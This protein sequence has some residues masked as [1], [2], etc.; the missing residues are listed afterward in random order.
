MVQLPKE[1]IAPEIPQVDITPSEVDLAVI[2]VLPPGSRVT[3]VSAHGAS[4]WAKIY[5]LDVVFV[6]NKKPCSYFMKVSILDR[7]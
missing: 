3:S 1:F 5:K 4:F 2:A 7:P 6:D